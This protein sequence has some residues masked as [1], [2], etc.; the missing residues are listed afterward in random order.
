M[1]LPLAVDCGGG[2]WRVRSS[3]CGLWCLLNEVVVWWW[4]GGGGGGEVFLC[5]FGVGGK[6]RT[7][8]KTPIERH[9][10]LSSLMK[11][12]VTSLD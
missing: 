2:E 7:K 6:R 5:V 3:S 1:G 10:S 12:K 8:T 4:G 11:G 9:W